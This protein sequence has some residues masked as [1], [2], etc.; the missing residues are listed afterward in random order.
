MPL[1][2]INTVSLNGATSKRDLLT[3][4]AHRRVWK[5]IPLE[6]LGGLVNDDQNTVEDLKQLV[7]TSERYH[8]HKHLLAMAAEMDAGLLRVELAIVLTS[9]GNRLWTQAENVPAGSAPP[10]RVVGELEPLYRAALTAERLYLGAY[11]PLVELYRRIGM[12]REVEAWVRRGKR[13]TDEIKGS[14]GRAAQIAQLIPADMVDDA[15]MYLD[16][17][18]LAT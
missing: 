6:C 16:Q 8:L 9:T 5:R 13:A 11:I 14:V 17:A 15:A 12:Q 3:I 18:R 7:L 2:W 1:H 10:A 4:I